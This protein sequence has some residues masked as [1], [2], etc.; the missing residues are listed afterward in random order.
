MFP[1]KIY[2]YTTTIHNPT[3][4]NI[5]EKTD[6]YLAAPN[7]VIRENSPYILNALAND[8]LDAHENLTYT[9]N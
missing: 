5:P 8:F 6:I 4:L 9:N 1:P 3:C 2:A 7:H